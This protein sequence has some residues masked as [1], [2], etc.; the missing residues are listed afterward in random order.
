MRHADIRNTI[1]V[2]DPNMDE[3]KRQQHY[4]LVCLV[5]GNNSWIHDLMLRLA[6]GRGK[7]EP[8]RP[9]YSYS[10]LHT[11][12]GKRAAQLNSPQRLG[13]TFP[14]FSMKRSEEHTSELQSRQYLV[15]RLLLE[16]KNKH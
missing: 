14:I 16:K 5:C 12:D 8:W 3:S 11:E 4:K 1:N 2:C 10:Q 9:P 7:I 15:C 6:T 13:G